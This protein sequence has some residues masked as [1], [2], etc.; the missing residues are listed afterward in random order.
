MQQEERTLK[1]IRAQ[2]NIRFARGD[3]ALFKGQSA[4]ASAHYKRAAEYF[5]G[6]DK[7]TVAAILSEAAGQI[8]EFE[9]RSLKPQFENALDLARSALDLTERLSNKSEWVR[10]KYRLALLQQV[11]SR[12]EGSNSRELLDDSIRNVEEALNTDS[13]INDFD[14]ASLIMLAGNNYMARAER[15]ENK[16]WESDIDAAIKIFDEISN[17]L[18]LE[19]LKVHRCR[20]YNNISAAWSLKS[21]RSSQDNRSLY[22]ENAKKALLRAIELSTGENQVDVWSA[23]Q[24]NL[25]MDLAEA[26]AA[27]DP[28]GA[29]FLRVQSIAAFNAS[30]EAFPQTALGLQSANTHLALGRVLLECA[31]SSKSGVRE[32]Y[33]VRSIGAYEAAAYM[34]DKE[35]SLG[36]WSHAQFSIGLAFFLHAEIAEPNVAAADL[37]N[38]L[39]CFDAAEPGYRSL[40]EQR[41]LKR[42]RSARSETKLRLQD[43]RQT[44]KSK[45]S[46]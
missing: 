4:V 37:E 5:A 8:Y 18:R 13:G 31:R 14:W 24:H 38:A 30:L 23:A 11:Q 39:S 33:L 16:D 34:L 41:D 9:R 25:G 21:R 27:A 20:L 10:A 44:L 35:A 36:A 45:P 3:A 22:K 42:L 12:K 1:E 28:Q 40:N 26:A 46:A 32:A 6:F 2:S 19:R 43:L 7:A 15:V 29:Q 17:D